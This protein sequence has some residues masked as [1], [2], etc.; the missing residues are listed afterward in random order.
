MTFKETRF[1]KADDGTENGGAPTPPVPTPN[2][3]NSGDPKDQSNVSKPDNES[4]PAGGSST[5]GQNNAS[6]GKQNKHFSYGNSGAGSTSNMIY[7]FTNGNINVQGV[8][9]ENSAAE[10]IME[11]GVEYAKHPW[12][13]SENTFYE[14]A[15]RLRKVQAVTAF[16]MGDFHKADKANAYDSLDLSGAKSGTDAYSRVGL[17]Y[18]AENRMNESLMSSQL[19]MTGDDGKK[20]AFDFGKD[21]LTD[22]QLHALAQEGCVEFGG[23]MVTF[24]NETAAKTFAKNY[25]DA[26]QE[27]ARREPFLNATTAKEKAEA[28]ATARVALISHLKQD[29][30]FMDFADLAKKPG[31]MSKEDFIKTECMQHTQRLD[32]EMFEELQTQA[33]FLNQ[34][35]YAECQNGMFGFSAINME[36]KQDRDQM[37]Q[38]FS[39]TVA[40]IGDDVNKLESS[41]QSL[42]GQQIRLQ[43]KISEKQRQIADL[44]SGKALIPEGMTKEDYLA[45]LTSSRDALMIKSQNLD[46]KINHLTSVRD[47]KGTLKSQ[48]DTIEEKLKKKLQQRETLTEIDKASKWAGD[49]A[50]QNKRSYGARIVGNKVFGQDMMFGSETYKRMYK[51]A[52]M[53]VRTIHRVSVGMELKF[54]ESHKTLNNASFLQSYKEQLQFTHAEDKLYL[55]AKKNGNKNYRNERQM[56]IESRKMLKTQEQLVNARGRVEQLQNLKRPLTK[57][58]LSELKSLERQIK[59]SEKHQKQMTTRQDAISARKQKR[60]AR[61]QKAA[62]KKAARIEKYKKSMLGKFTDRV[63]KFWSKYS[64]NALKQKV[65]GALSKKLIAAFGGK[66]LI[67]ALLAGGGA[68]LLLILKMSVMGAAIIVIIFY[69]SDLIPKGTN[70]AE[71]LDMGVDGMNY[72]QV[73]V[74]E[75]STKLARSFKSVA[76]RDAYTHYSEMDASAL[77]AASANG[78]AVM[79]PKYDWYRGI[80]MGK[81]GNIYYAEDRSQKAFGVNDNLVPITSMMH[82]RF[83]DEIG[84]LNWN[85]ARGYVYYMYSQSHDT[86]GYYAKPEDDCNS[87]N[88]Y[89]VSFDPKTALSQVLKSNNKVVYSLSRPTTIQAK[90]SNIYVHGYDKADQLKLRQEAAHAHQDGLSA[91]YDNLVSNFSSLWGDLLN[92]ESEETKMK[93]NGIV[94]D[95]WSGSGAYKKP[96]DSKGTCNDAVAIASLALTETRKKTGNDYNEARNLLVSSTGTYGAEQCPHYEHMHNPVGCKDAD[97]WKLDVSTGVFVTTKE[98]H[99]HRNTAA[100]VHACDWSH[101]S[102]LDKLGNEQHYEHTH[103]SGC[104]NTYCGLNEHTHGIT[105]CN[106]ETHTHGA[107]C[108]KTTYG[109]CGNCGA[110]GL[111]PGAA[112]TAAHA[113]PNGGNGWEQYQYDVWSC[114]KTE[115]SHTNADGS[116]SSDCNNDAC[117]NKDADG[118]PYEHTHGADCCSLNEHTHGASCCIYEEHKHSPS[119]CYYF[120]GSSDTG[121][122]HTGLNGVETYGKVQHK[123]LAWKGAASPGCYQTVWVCPGHCGSHMT[124]QVDVVQDMTYESLVTYDNFKVHRNLQ[125]ADFDTNS[126]FNKHGSEDGLSD[127]FVTVGAWKGFWN[128]KALEWFRIFNTSP[129]VFFQSFGKNLVYFGASAVDK[130]TGAVSNF[131][132]WIVGKI[133]GFDTQETAEAAA[134]DAVVGDDVQDIFQFEGW[135][136]KDDRGN[137]VLNTSQIEDVDSLYPSDENY[138]TAIENWRDIGDVRFPTGAITTMYDQ[139][140]TEIMEA[141]PSDLEGYRR[142]VIQT[143]LES[144]GRY[145]FVTEKSSFKFDEAGRGQCDNPTYVKKVLEK[146]LDTTIRNPGSNTPSV[147]DWNTLA[148]ST[149][150]LK[151]GDLLVW[152]SYQFGEKQHDENDNVVTGDV[153]IY[154]GNINGKYV[155]IHNVPGQAV[156]GATF[157][158]WGTI[159]RGYKRVDVSRYHH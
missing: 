69:L 25:A 20:F 56:R 46:A 113:C 2:G 79:S 72:I 101:C 40:K 131:F 70:L 91:F 117:I 150:G 143:A 93:K 74:N 36:T 116:R 32:N 42:N 135:Y 84:Y 158:E 86:D 121:C 157:E 18:A 6:Q 27:R 16:V 100:S 8:K 98:V 49:E 103:G 149:S 29:N 156:N 21:H 61:R 71:K 125:D 128:T 96:S 22:S 80:N 154:V 148:G 127:N 85:T 147:A 24:D 112:G 73:I 19:M 81:I 90:C 65:V 159:P 155:V 66:T 52:D 41:I 11:A 146:A 48:M 17:G 30:D 64:P 102:N 92:S 77:A 88:L 50:Y 57:D 122:A 141:L 4:A 138:K 75:A 38:N 139:K 95:D 76:E 60:D 68:F 110:M 145:T 107:S 115:H 28:L 108:T 151:P 106:K 39:D 152:S 9:A 1:F 118:N 13:T 104:N 45:R 142:E 31:N 126:L 44:K 120:P 35:G 124:P 83:L 105:C 33:A 99:V 119:I 123:H 134:Q 10:N 63:S 62:T 51:M 47:K 53:G 15:Q 133:G 137:V 14:N 34:N 7:Q 144:V 55:E 132:N 5:G 23:R 43:S 37:M 67:G 3:M 54:I 89:S 114:G 153:C 12:R 26:M 59:R 97:C 58:E 136:K 111:T 130:V 140:I 94:V 82:F 129:A 109:V 78:E 87:A